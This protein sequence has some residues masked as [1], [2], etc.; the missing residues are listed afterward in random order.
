MRKPHWMLSSLLCLAL[1]GC[2]PY[3]PQLVSGKGV[4]YSETQID[5][6]TYEVRFDGGQAMDADMVWAFWI[7]RCAQ[8][9]RDKGHQYFTMVTRNDVGQAPAVHSGLRP[10][11]LTAGEGGHLIRTKGGGYVTVY[12]YLPGASF[13]TWHSKSMIQMFDGAPPAGVIYAVDAAAVLRQLDGFIE[14]PVRNT[15]PN[16]D[17]V[18]AKAR[19]RVNLSPLRGT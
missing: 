17:A 11:V 19:I 4:G 15:V 16:K 14:H 13:T 9:T 6:V 1:A 18:L 3:S 8:L 12:S 2:A 7:Y 10:A 5:D